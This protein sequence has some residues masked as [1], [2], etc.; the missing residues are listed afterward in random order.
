VSRRRRSALAVLAAIGTFFAGARV[1]GA[2]PS[3]PNDPAF[4]LQW[5]LAATGAPS[6]WA[7]TTG[8][9]T[10]IAIVDSGID[11]H[12]EDLSG[13]IVGHVSCVNSGGDPSKCDSSGGDD[14]DGHGTHVAGIAAAE[15]DNGRGVAG[16]A[17][18]AQ[19]LDVK[20]LSESCSV[21][22]TDCTASGNA[23]DVAAGIVYAADHGATAI[24]LSLGNEVQSVFGP[25]FSQA[26]DYAWSKGAIPVVAA[27]NDFVLPSGFSNEPAI[28]VGALNRNGGKASYANN[29]G[30]AKWALMAP[31]GESD[32][33]DSCSKDPQGVLSTYWLSNNA[34]N[35][36]ACLAGTS[37]AAP[38]V[39]GAVALLRSLG[40]SPQQTVDQ[41]LHTAKPLGASDVYGAGA[42]DVA[43]AVSSAPAPAGDQSTT[44]AVTPLSNP[45]ATAPPQ[46]E[47][48]ASGTPATQAPP[49]TFELPPPVN[50]PSGDATGGATV[51]T[52]NVGDGVP[53]GPA[54]VAGL[55]ASSVAAAATWVFFRRPFT[56]PQ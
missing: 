15:T 45:P 38:H 51:H 29:I 25:S 54:I 28:V 24:N 13:K 35:A 5:N 44:N 23:D 22:Q 50:V 39:S 12:H 46:V 20:V 48:G 53:K 21:A 56:R 32:S 52:T 31:G 36:Y 6:A 42:L 2:V 47:A 7:R 17:P 10:T 30:S 9:G 4:G 49:P 37:M 41:L 1:A 19:L 8:Q 18:D 27:G 16:M 43:A 55:M 3:Q 11:L 14:D 26:I 40:L 34:V 33:G